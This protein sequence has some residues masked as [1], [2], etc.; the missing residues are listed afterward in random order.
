MSNL[1]VICAW[2]W[3][4]EQGTDYQPWTVAVWADMVRRNVSRPVRIVCLTHE[5]IA[6]EG[7]EIVRPPR[8]FEA[9]RIPTWGRR[10]P[11]CLR[12]LV[13]F[14]PDLADWLGERVLNM[15]LDCVV[16]GP[17]DPL[18]DVPDDFRILRGTAPARP[19][20]GSL[21]LLTAGARPEVYTDF[22]PERAVQAGKRFLGSDQAWIM[23]KLPGEA[24]FG[25]EHGVDWWANTRKPPHPTPER[26]LFF[27]GSAKP[28][29]LL[30]MP[31]VARHYRR[32]GGRRGLVLGHRVTVWEEARAAMARE[33]FD[34]V[35]AY[36]H[37]AEQWP[38]RVDAV[39][40]SREEARTMAGV[41]GFDT[42]VECGVRSAKAA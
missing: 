33:T 20:N 11:Q 37:V 32:R 21:M 41:L 10:Q 30:K 5:D 13:L 18:F 24:T 22:T 28:W 8:D 14:R 4:Q 2:W 7:V 1:P 19:Y 17:L 6:V 3:R 9:V 25:L 31:V 39:V 29:K 34:G 15:D 12:R 27:M 26:L 40:E 42:V 38:G 36:P 35:I 16:T 23:A